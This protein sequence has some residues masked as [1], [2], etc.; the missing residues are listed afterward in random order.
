MKLY[1]NELKYM[2]IKQETVDQL[3][4]DVADLLQGKKSSVE[5]PDE[6]KSSY[7][8]PLLHRFDSVK[9]GKQL[10]MQKV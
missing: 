9:N 1:G 4:Q 7:T 3:A 5:Y 6:G 8:H 10:I 2:E